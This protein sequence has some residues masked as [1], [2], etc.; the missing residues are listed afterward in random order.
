MFKV[1]SFEKIMELEDRYTAILGSKTGIV[2]SPRR[3]KKTKPGE[4]LARRSINEAFAQAVR[5]ATGL[6]DATF[7]S[8]HRAI[9]AEKRVGI[10]G[11]GTFT[12]R[13]RKARK[14]RHAE[15]TIKATPT[16]PGRS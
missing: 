3:R 1:P 12:V 10:E 8:L 9:R 11:F 7:E 6:R 2:E 5:K 16:L 4:F 14:G 13:S 15:I